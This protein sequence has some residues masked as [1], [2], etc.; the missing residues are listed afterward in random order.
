V[1]VSY[2]GARVVL[3]GIAPGW[4]A[5]DVRSALLVV[6]LMVTAAFIA[7]ARRLDPDKLDRLTFRSPFARLVL[8][9]IAVVY[10]VLVSGVLVSGQ[11]SITGCLGWPVYSPLVY[12]VDSHGAGNILR[13]ILSVIGVLLS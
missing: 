9:T 6:A 7:N 11:N 1:E 4:A 12:Q 3:G 13:L 10:A 2:F 5:V 8:G